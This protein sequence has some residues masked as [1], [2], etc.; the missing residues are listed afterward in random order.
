MPDLG[1]IEGIKLPEPMAISHAGGS[2]FQA[3]AIFTCPRYAALKIL[4][5]KKQKKEVYLAFGGIIHKDALGPYEATPAPIDPEATSRAVQDMCDSEE[6]QNTY[7]AIDGVRRTVTEFVEV[8]DSD[9]DTLPDVAKNQM[10]AWDEKRYPAEKVVASERLMVS[11][12]KQPW[13]GNVPPEAEGIR[14]CGRLD[15]AIDDGGA[16]LRD[17]KTAKTPLDGTWMADIGYTRQ[18]SVYRYIWAALRG[19]EIRNVG[20]F[21]LTKH[22]RLAT[23]QKHAK[24][25]VLKCFSYRRVFSELLQAI[26]LLRHHE[27]EKTW[28]CNPNACMGKFGPCE[29]VPLCYSDQFDDENE[30]R[31][32]LER[33]EH[34]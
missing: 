9:R 28:P 26:K 25:I 7:T 8:S 1:N 19:S 16:C 6:S 29:F 32:T 10:I 31:K 34:P 33:R 4:G 13:D 3:G 27:K 17:L 14:V 23:I 2:G 12:L 21:Q 20:L 15:L 22:K 18:L 11:P 30:Y 5:W 24:E